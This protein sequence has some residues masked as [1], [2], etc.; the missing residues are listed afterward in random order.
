METIRIYQS[1][2]CKVQVLNTSAEAGMV[3]LSQQL[4][5]GTDHHQLCAGGM[6][7]HP[8]LLLLVCMARAQN[9]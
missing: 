1:C 4:L 6:S 7:I 9:C 8:Q 3:Q 5:L 2:S